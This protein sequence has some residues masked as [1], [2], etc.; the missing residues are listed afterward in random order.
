MKTKNFLR[1]LTLCLTLLLMHFAQRAAAQS[2]DDTR[3]HFDHAVP[4]AATSVPY[5]KS[6]DLYWQS[7]QH[8]AWVAEGQTILINNTAVAV[9]CYFHENFTRMVFDD[10]ITADTPCVAEN[11]GKVSID[12]LPYYFNASSEAIHLDYTCTPLDGNLVVGRTRPATGEYVE[13][14][15]DIT[16]AFHNDL[17]TPNGIGPMELV[18]AITINGQ[19]G[20]VASVDCSNLPPRLT[21]TQPITA[22][23]D[24]TIVLPSGLFVYDDENWHL[25]NL[26]DITLQYT[27]D[28]PGFVMTAAEWC[29]YCPPYDC[30]IPEGYTAFI[31]PTV[32]PGEIVL[33]EIGRDIPHGTPVIIN[34]S[35][36]A[37][38]TKVGVERLDTPPAA[39]AESRYLF[40]VAGNVSETFYYAD[41]YPLYDEAG[42]LYK[43]SYNK[44]GKDLG[45][46]FDSEDGQELVCK[47]HRAFLAV[48][49]SL[50]GISGTFRFVRAEETGLTTPQATTSTAR[51]AQPYSVSG[52]AATAHLPH[53][54]LITDGKKR[55]TH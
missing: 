43:L 13:Q 34:G 50:E 14:L 25:T 33:E 40:G 23:G 32:K 47:P 30:R 12:I 15:T 24:Y 19:T 16:F 18:E 49:H 41:F 1:T 46:Y 29:T 2:G 54:I 7:G 51:H 44:Q 36:P 11:E 21:L 55:L 26:N 39:V 22:D 37:T 28:S 6:I 20:L 48:P 9:T 4:A 27:V 8:A 31:V 53:A 5:L 10:V 52:Q 45:W 42:Y 38:G 3:L 35:R 17:L